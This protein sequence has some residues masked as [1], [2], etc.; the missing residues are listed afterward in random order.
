MHGRV[1]S[2]PSALVLERMLVTSER[3]GSECVTPLSGKAKVHLAV[4]LISMQDHL[5]ATSDICSWLSS[6]PIDKQTWRHYWREIAVSIAPMDACT[7]HTAITRKYCFMRKACPSEA[8][9][10]DPQ[11]NAMRC[12]DVLAREGGKHWNLLRHANGRATTLVG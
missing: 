4:S 10:Y 9:H 1:G 12:Q 7:S 6:H 5:T 11:S 3:L 8:D 2:R